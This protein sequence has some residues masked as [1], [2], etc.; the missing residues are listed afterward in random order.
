MLFVSVVAQ[1]HQV[2]AGKVLLVPTVVCVPKAEQA[3]DH[4]AQQ[5]HRCTA[6]LLL[7]DFV[8][9]GHTTITAV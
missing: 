4:S 2:Y 3:E 9:A 6:A 1:I 7:T 8:L 5:E